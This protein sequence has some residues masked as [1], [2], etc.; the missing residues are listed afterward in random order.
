M[1][2]HGL[3]RPTGVCLLL[4]VFGALACYAGLLLDERTL[5]ATVIVAAAMAVLSLSVAIAQWVK[6]GRGGAAYV[7][8]DGNVLGRASARRTPAEGVTSKRAWLRSGMT[9]LLRPSYVT[10]TAL[11]ERVDQYG[12][13][14]DRW[15]GAPP[16]ERGLYR[17]VGTLLRWRSPFGLFAVR[18]HIAAT[19]ETLVLPE[20]SD[21]AAQGAGVSALGR[22]AGLV[23]TEDSGTVR[24]Y[25]S[26]DPIRRIAWRHSARR[27]RLMT[28]ESEGNERATLL[29]V[30]NAD[31]TDGVDARRLDGVAAALRPYAKA[32]RGMDVMATDGVHVAEGEREVL[33]FLASVRPA[34]GRDDAHGRDRL[35]RR[36]CTVLGRT[37]MVLR[38]MCMVRGATCTI[39]RA[40]CGISAATC[41]ASVGNIVRRRSGPVEV[42][43]CDA[44]DSNGLTASLQRSPI[45]SAVRVLDPTPQE[46]V[47]IP[48]ERAGTSHER[49]EIMQVPSRTMHKRPETVQ[50]RHA[51]RRMASGEGG[52]AVGGVLG[53]ADKA[54]RIPR[55]VASLALLTY[56]GIM[57]KALAG[58]VEPTGWWIWFAA[59]TFAVA[60][61]VPAV[62]GYPLRDGRPARF[63]HPER[64]EVPG[65]TEK[66]HP[67]R[68]ALMRVLCFT[69]VL[70]AATLTLIVLR[71]RDVPVA[72]ATGGPGGFAGLR[73]RFV[74]ALSTGFDQ[75]DRQLPPLRVSP[76]SDVLLIL[77]IAVA[78]LLIR[79]L[80]L[81]RPAVPL[82]AVLPVVALAADA[83]MLGHVAPWW[84]VALLAFAFPM[85]VWAS[86][87]RPL[88]P[89]RAVP[90]R[91]VSPRA[92]PAVLAA[93]TVMAVTLAGTPAAETLAYRVPLSIGEGGGMFSSN[94]VSPLIDLK[95]NIDAGSDST[96]FSY[97]A[98]RRLYLKLS[99]LD[100]F[101]GDTWGYDNEL[102]IDAGLYGSGIRLGRDASD[103]LTMEQRR[104]GD[105]L[106][107][108]AWMLG[109]AGYGASG[110][111]SGGGTQIDER[112]LERYEATANVRIDTLRSRF[113]PVPGIASGA[114][115]IGSSWL[116]YR[117]GSL[118]NR[119]D[120]TSDGMRYTVTGTYVDP[121]TSDAGFSTL[122]PVREVV[123]ALERQRDDA[124]DRVAGWFE[125]RRTIA[126]A[127]L[128]E[129]RDGFAV[130]RASIDVDGVVSAP[131]GTR[132]GKVSAYSMAFSGEQDNDRVWG[133]GTTTPS[134]GRYSQHPSHIAFDDAFETRYGA[135]GAG[136]V[137]GFSENGDAVTLVMPLTDMTGSDGSSDGRSDSGASTVWA[138]NAITILFQSDTTT[139]IAVEAGSADNDRTT[140]RRILAMA[141]ASDKAAHAGRYTSLPKTLPANVRAVVRRSRADG[142]AAKAGSY[143][144]QVRAMRWLVGYFT[145]KANRFTYSLDAPDGDGRSNMQVIDDFL[146]PDTGHAGYCQHYASA[147]A[148]LGRAMGVPTRIVL[149]YNAG[150]N[151]RDADG[152]FPVASR[153]L[154]AWV[155]AYLDGVGWVS[156]DVTPPSEENGTLTA[157]GTTAA[158]DGSSA[159]SSGTL[160]G[161]DG[162]AVTEFDTTGNGGSSARRNG[163]EDKTAGKSADA[164][165]GKEAGDGS[166]EASGPP[167]WFTHVAAWFAALPVWARV[168][169]AVGV[170]A[171]ALVACVLAP[172]AVRTL[173]RRRCVAAARRAA[174]A[175]GGSGGSGDDDSGGGGGGSGGDGGD[176][177]AALRAAAWRMAWR[178]I[179]REG[180]A[181]GARWDA[182]DTDLMIADRIAD[183]WPSGAD[184]D[185]GRRAMILRVARAADSVA[186]GGAAPQVDDLADGLDALFAATRR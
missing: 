7:E 157:D 10:A 148:V 84:A 130:V 143:G 86:S 140:A 32:R 67:V 2:R 180:R 52:G 171:V 87:P 142:V 101:D 95:R 69:V 160:T 110:L 161:D 4:A 144:E 163:A 90:P 108:Y 123:A 29:L 11:Y 30:V 79:I 115:N 138:Q 176:D 71:L 15:A 169:L 66:R 42:L 119:A 174:S 47:E 12:N 19:G 166:S 74:A 112:T 61:L 50:V 155:E 170:A 9:R 54:L 178:E 116:R 105:P 126:D 83:A 154:H 41:T 27:G 55:I 133:G 75:L 77:V 37:C 36:M 173:R 23:D 43:V 14:V 183:V 51:D 91:A 106:G 152:Y 134:A 53:G 124:S 186:F 65:T 89:P 49:S 6:A 45:E 17:Q 107:V 20:A 21:T 64:V 168:A 44:S 97:S 8:G 25:E 28:R 120:A 76:A 127:G 117:D 81:W 162:S 58:L 63:V 153:Q 18:R 146:D 40:T 147:L 96:V 1:R 99:T 145:D 135:D 131:D 35:R 80:L 167:V 39:P 94:T 34:G 172:R 62:P 48:H 24:G 158:S 182:A 13:V 141:A 111:E 159:G 136:I 177:A 93:L 22:S 59:G 82:I 78:V 85:S 16:R 3:I 118:Y 100:A 70:V 72:S 60:A 165:E 104:G 185:H 88:V 103:D 102:A 150:T 73:T 38:R 151:A 137:Y 113:L 109:Y 5:M 46:R 92:V 179:R 56:F 33:R 57:L 114:N 68:S 149:G 31:G 122:D 128:G 98:D 175:G 164:T 132:I 156:F 26:G 121:I 125:A 139:S 129:T 181:A 184:D